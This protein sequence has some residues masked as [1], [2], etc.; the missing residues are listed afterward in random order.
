MNNRGLSPQVVMPFPTAISVGEFT[1]YTFINKFGRN[2]DCDA[3]A[4][5]TA[6][7]IGR[8]I[9]DN[10]IAGATMWVP[11]TEARIHA[12][13]STDDEDGGGVGP[14]GALTI[15][16]FGLDADYLLQQEDLTLDGDQAIN[17][18]K[19][20]TMIH[21]MYV[22]TA[23]TDGRNVGKITATAAT[24]GTVTAAITIDNNQTAMAIYQ[25]PADK[26]GYLF[27]FYASLQRRSQATKYVD[28]M[29]MLKEFGGV[30]RLHDTFA[31]ASSANHTEHSY[32]HPFV[33]PA[34]AYLKVVADP[35]A[36]AQDISAGFDLMLAPA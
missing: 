18:V 31:M 17:T 35:S 15:R 14:T 5:A 1:A 9:W 22:L 2:P 8:D 20:Y 3:A 13:V 36:D 28:A 12:L 26:T 30:W 6:V 4:S 16:I 34:K 19:A 7:V 29:L 33:V 11:P 24:D 25:I 10:G 23:G 21:R 32:T 27:C